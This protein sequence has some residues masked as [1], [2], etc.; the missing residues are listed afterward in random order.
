VPGSSRITVHKS[1][2]IPASA[3]QV[4]D[5][6]CDWAGMLRWWLPA[7]KG[8]L[9]GP[10]LIGCELIGT[11]GSVPRT[12]RMTLSDGRM[13]EETIIYQNGETRRIHYTKSDDQ[14]VTGYFATTYVDDLEDTRC[15][16]HISSVFDISNPAGHTTA[17]ARY[18]AVY[19][20]MFDGYS[21]YFTRSATSSPAEQPTVTTG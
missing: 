9:Q 17:A 11:P 3:E 15:A 19:M 14:A 13:A 5:L 18:E 21:R 8:G 20:A 16:L 1:A 4:W 6:I 10:A 2:E 12:R 7:G